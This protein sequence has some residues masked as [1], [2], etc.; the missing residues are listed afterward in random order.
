M[1]DRLREAAQAALSAMD[2]MATDSRCADMPA[3]RTSEFD[4]AREDLRA[5]LAEQDA[6]PVAR[7]VEVAAMIL[8][9]CGCST[10]NESL[11]M[12]VAGRIS[13]E[14]DA[15]AEQ[16]MYVPKGWKLVPE[17]PTE[18][19]LAATSWPGC[20]TTDYAHMIAAAPM[21]PRREWQGLT[22]EEVNGLWVSQPTISKFARA[23]EAKLKEKNHGI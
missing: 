6:E 18:E 12:R 22:D 9:D 11:L 21:P 23:I 5:A 2:D 14:I 19:M 20:A 4:A 16:E 7:A 15:L 13:K 8:S 3:S 17:Q 10:D 1:T